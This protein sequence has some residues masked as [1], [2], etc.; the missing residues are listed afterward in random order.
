M[1]FKLETVN[2]R[3][4]KKPCKNAIFKGFSDSNDKIYEVEINTL[5]ELMSLIK[6][7]K[8]D[9]DIFASDREDVLPIITIHDQF[10]GCF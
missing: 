4:T 9:I 7:V 3:N 1:L 2:P 6:E 8:T 5:E 10:E